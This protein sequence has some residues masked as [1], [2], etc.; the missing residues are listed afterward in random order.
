MKIGVL[1]DIHGNARAFAAVKDQLRTEGCERC[2]FL[3][4][5]CGYYFRQNEI[6]DELRAWPSLVS[7]SGNHDRF[8]LDSL[9]D[10][11]RAHIYEEAFGRSFH[12]LQREISPENLDFLQQ[13]EAGRVLA[14]EGMALF[15]GS[16]WEPLYEYI[17]PD[18]P[19]QRFA[20]LEYDVVFLGH[21]HR[22]MVREY[23]GKLIVNP[24]SVGQ[25]RDGGWPSYAVYDTVTRRAEIRRVPY[26]VMGQIEEVRR[27]GDPTPYLIEAL[28]RIQP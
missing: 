13:L 11:S 28:L 6:L 15:H 7:V 12:H 16:P 3:G 10:E 24:G 22:P 9:T 20:E 25:P 8:F 18:T 5:I 1:S 14:G 19:L 2:F 23:A 27:S 21:T 26:D 17:Y 4:D